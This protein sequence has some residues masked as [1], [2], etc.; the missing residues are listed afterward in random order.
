MKYEQSRYHIQYDSYKKKSVSL[1]EYQD[2]SEREE[3]KCSKGRYERT[4][5]D[6]DDDYE[7]QAIVNR[8]VGDLHPRGVN[9]N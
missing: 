8:S 7:K 2:E 6:C 4:Y 9:Q 3:N 1:F 5:S